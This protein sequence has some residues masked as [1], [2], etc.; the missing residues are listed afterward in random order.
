M[1]QSHYSSTLYLMKE[2]DLWCCYHYSISTP[3]RHQQRVPHAE[4]HLQLIRV[5]LCITLASPTARTEESAVVKL[6]RRG[7]KLFSNPK[8]VAFHHPLMGRVLVKQRD[9]MQ[10]TSGLWGKSGQLTPASL[11]ALLLGE[12]G[13]IHSGTPSGYS[14]THIIPLPCTTYHTHYTYLLATRVTPST[15]VGQ[16]ALRAPCPSSSAPIYRYLGNLAVALHLIHR[17]KSQHILA[18]VRD[19][20][21]V[22][23]SLLE[24]S[25]ASFVKM[26]IL[27]IVK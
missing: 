17:V 9:E 22:Q 21:F 27:I 2:A 5:P 26:R 18:N 13:D 3:A 14:H 7:K 19:W 12:A 23:H 16:G 25:V 20:H 11:V 10:P 6:G 15:L 1:L 24:W 8:W 4:P